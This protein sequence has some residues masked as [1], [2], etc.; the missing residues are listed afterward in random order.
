MNIVI[1]RKTPHDDKS[2]DVKWDLQMKPT[3]QSMIFC[4]L[5]AAIFIGIYVYDQNFE[6]LE[7]IGSILLILSLL[8]L[9]NVFK[10][11]SAFKNRFEKVKR[12]PPG[13]NTELCITIDN[14]L[15][16]YETFEIK[17]E[18]KWSVFN[19]YKYVDNMI[20]LLPSDNYLLSYVIYKDELTEQE[21]SELYNFLSKIFP[22][23]K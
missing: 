11:R 13:V 17:Q 16:K 12:V 14:T 10:S 21:F 15:F 7:T 20:F 2:D 23:K 9:F 4:F 3:Y 1:K 6:I 18:I 22:E 8:T 19:Y 5:I